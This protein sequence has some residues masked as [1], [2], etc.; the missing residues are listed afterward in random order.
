MKKSKIKRYVYLILMLLKYLSIWPAAYFMRLNDKNKNILLV[1]E[2]GMDAR[3]NAYH[4]INY[5]W[6]KHPEI[7]AYFVISKNSPDREKL[8]N[9]GYI[10][11][12]RSLKHYLYFWISDVK[13]S[14]HIMGYSPDAALFNKL[15]NFGLV[16]GKKIFL[17]HGITKDYIAELT[18][19]NINLDLF[20]CG[21]KPEFEYVKLKYNFP[22]NVVKYLGMARF[23]ALYD[24]NI[25]KQIIIMPT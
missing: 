11:E 21:A 2:R 7:I 8:K 19:P 17:Q 22:S 5:I 18:Y 3:D 6:D 25:K 1:S 24:I 23:D 16:R 4:L 15:D 12:Y 13:I 14:T 10:I 9:K 20:V